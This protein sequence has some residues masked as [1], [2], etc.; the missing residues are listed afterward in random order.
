L[1]IGEIYINEPD[2]LVNWIK[3]SVLVRYFL[4]VVIL[5]NSKILLNSYTLGVKLYPHE[6]ASPNLSRKSVCPVFEEVIGILESNSKYFL[7]APIG[8]WNLSWS[9]RVWSSGLPVKE[10]C[11]PK[12]DFIGIKPPL[13]VA[14]LI[15]VLP[16]PI[17]ELGPPL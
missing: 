13:S 8:S 15:S 10:D 5:F 11:G 4:S 16:T 17:F 2:V 12:I 7:L 3:G 1:F 6:L 14:N 9:I